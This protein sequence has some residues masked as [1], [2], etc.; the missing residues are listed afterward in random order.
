MKET[1]APFINLLRVKVRFDNMM[2]PIQWTIWNLLKP[3]R[4]NLDKTTE[5]SVTKDHYKVSSSFHK[6]KKIE[7][8]E[9]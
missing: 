2:L 5:N 3:M 6:Y 7:K 4:L 9:I 8:Y 1:F